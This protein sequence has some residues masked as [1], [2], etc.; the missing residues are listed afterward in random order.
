M[1]KIFLIIMMIL[2]GMMSFA[3]EISHSA[4][5]NISFRMPDMSVRLSDEYDDYY[6]EFDLRTV[7][8]MYIAN[9]AIGIVLSAI[10]SVPIITFF[11]L[12]AMTGGGMW[13]YISP[14]P[15]YGF[16]M[17][18]AGIMMMY[19]SIKQAQCVRRNVDEPWYKYEMSKVMRNVGIITLTTS[20]V[21]LA[22]TI[23]YIVLSCSTFSFFVFP[24]IS[25][26]SGVASLSQLV[27]GITFLVLGISKMEEWAEIVFPEVSVV[28]DDKKGYNEGYAV[29]VALRIRI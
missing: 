12:G 15:V 21:P 19:L 6:R 17:T 2:V 28:H 11:I 24:L 9:R 16:Q 13:P 8:S 20:V 14:V 29:N 22:A 18:I 4:K 25:I 26:V 23:P 7:R 3:N 1:K 27:L 10:S 5:N